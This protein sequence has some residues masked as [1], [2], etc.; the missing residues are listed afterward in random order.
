MAAP[1]LWTVSCSIGM[2]AWRRQSNRKQITSNTCMHAY[3]RMG[4]QASSAFIINCY[5]CVV[6]VRVYEYIHASCAHVYK[7]GKFSSV[8]LVVFQRHPTYD[9]MQT[10]MHEVYIGTALHCSK[11]LTI[12]MPAS[13][14]AKRCANLTEL[15][16]PI[17]PATTTTSPK[18]V[19]PQSRS[20]PAVAHSLPSMPSWR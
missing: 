20:T 13:A 17:T 1:L 18:E 2:T 7:H 14:S 8:L 9:K 5:K 4:K 15:P 11:F 16:T 19:L 3:I 12:Y 10:F 6:H